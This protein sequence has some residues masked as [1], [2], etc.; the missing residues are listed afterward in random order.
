MKT[1]IIDNYDSFTY[2]LFHYVEQIEGEAI[3]VRNDQ[4]TPEIMDA[5]EK[6]IIGPGPGLPETAGFTLDLI[7]AYAPH[8]RFLGICLGHEAL[9]IA[10]GARLRNLRE[11]LHGRA[12]KTFLNRSESDGLFDQIPPQ[13]QT[14]R[15]HSFVIDEASLP[16]EFKII[17]SDESATI[18]AIKHRNFDLTGLQFHPESI[19]TP[20]G[21]QII[22]NWL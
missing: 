13:I 9:A 5:H 21:F 6:I 16:K 8:K 7:R 1:L 20:H 17:A 3:V 12:I 18:Q 15:Y 2:N 14:G 4:V 10:F 22:K 19:L 11:V